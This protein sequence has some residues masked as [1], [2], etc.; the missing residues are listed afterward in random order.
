MRLGRRAGS[1]LLGRVRSPLRFITAFLTRM[2]QVIILSLHDAIG[3]FPELA[4]HFVV[5]TIELF[6]LRMG[7]SFFSGLLSF[8]TKV[9]EGTPGYSQWRVPSPRLGTGEGVC[10]AQFDL[11]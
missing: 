8:T 5:M 2:R 6:K 11:G 9:K 1:A 10:G 4:M 7:W 3:V